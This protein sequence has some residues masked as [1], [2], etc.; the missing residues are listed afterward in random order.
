VIYYLKTNE[1]Q[2]INIDVFSRLLEISDVIACCVEKDN[3]NNIEKIILHSSITRENMT[4]ILDYITDSDNF[5]FT[6]DRMHKNELL[7]LLN[8]CHYLNIK[9]I[10]EMLIDKIVNDISTFNEQELYEYFR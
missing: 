9:E 3:I 7:C 6:V 4:Y 8:A 5:Y 2:E 10:E 1:C